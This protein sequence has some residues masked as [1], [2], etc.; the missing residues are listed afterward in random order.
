MTAGYVPPTIPLVETGTPPR[1]WSESILA[2]SSPKDT[3]AT[4]SDIPGRADNSNMTEEKSLVR[5]ESRAAE[6]LA[7]VQKELEKQQA[8][9]SKESKPTTTSKDTV[10]SYLR[11]LSPCRALA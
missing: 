1:E 5:E 2:S 8:Q 6:S 4:Y 10:S 3:P 11:K 7:R 9:P